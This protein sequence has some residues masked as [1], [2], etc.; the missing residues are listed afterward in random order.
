MEAPDDLRTE[1][2]VLRRATVD[3]ADAAFRYASDPEVTTHLTFTP[4]ESVE[5]VVEFLVHAEQSWEAGTAYA[6]AITTRVNN[7]VVGIIDL[8]VT[9]RGV[10]LGYALER[11]AW[12]LGYMT[13]AI[14]A[15]I[16]WVLTSDDVYRVWAY[17]GVANVASQRVLEKA[18]MAREGTLH[19]W[20]TLPNIEATPQNA[21]VYAIWR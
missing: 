7:G 14:R 20:L 21:Y 2:L 19:R 17:V 5:P 16:G 10:M 15:V 9:D 8:E 12:G 13:E 6:L 18:G 1:R 3:D 11:S 4:H